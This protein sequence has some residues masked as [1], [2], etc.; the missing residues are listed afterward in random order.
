MDEGAKIYIDSYDPTGSCQ[1]FRWDYV[2]TWEYR[3]PYAVTNRVCYV[4]EKSDEILIKN[5]S[6]YNKAKITRFPVL[7]IPNTTDRL[8]E[9]YSILVKQYSL[10]EEEYDFWERIQNISGNV[11][12]LYDVTPM[13]VYGNIECC[14]DPGEK[15]LGYFSVS[16]VTEKRMFIQDHFYGLPH[17]YTYCATDTLSG[18]LPETGLNSE[19]W[20]IEDFSD[21]IPPF[22]V[23]TTYKECA[24]C[25]IRGTPERPPYWVY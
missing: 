24:D 16:A 20:V 23:I 2:E 5:T 4:T 15:V 22:W 21:E 6:I 11:G 9:T 3:I 18:Q 8:K 17:F 13:A 7:F 14:D 1:F 10:N 19:F 25:S 12:N